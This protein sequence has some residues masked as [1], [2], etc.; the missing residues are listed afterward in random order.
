[1]KKALLCCFG[2]ILAMWVAVSPAIAQSSLP[3]GAIASSPDKPGLLPKFYNVPNDQVPGKLGSI[4][5]YESVD[6]PEGA[7]AWRVVYRSQT[8]SDVPV[9]VS[10]LIVAPKFAPPEAKLPV[11]SWAHGTVGGARYCAPSNVPY[12][13]SDFVGF[14]SF[15]STVPNDYGIPG[16]SAFIKAGYVVVASDYQGLGAGEKHEYLVGLSQAR[17]A[18]DIVR[19]ARELTPAGNK[20]ALL[21]WSQGGLGVVTAGENASY[22]PDLEI[23]GIA[24][25]AP[26]NPASFVP[27]SIPPGQSTGGPRIGRIIL[28]ERAYTWAYDDLHLSD[29]FTDIGIKAAEA[30]SRQCIQQLSI[31][32]DTAGGDSV[33]FKENTN[34]EAWAAKFTEN[35]I[36]QHDSNIPVLVM[37]GTADNIIPPDSTDLYVREACRFRTPVFY[38]KYTG[39]DHRSLLPAA[40]ADF[41]TWIADRFANEPAPFNCPNA[42]IK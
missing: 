38:I 35:A 30:A 24:A 8:A 21:G 5:K 41:T 22:A 17:N 42:K 34:L 31:T 28:L 2:I 6:A 37:Q 20:A 23:V 9:A 3:E 13:V 15:E 39:K 4:I 33:L 12:P 25:L 29:V 11:V 26:A 7:L 14:P 32:G 19:A 40:E 16:L 18:L 10:G 36:G 1:M 27:G